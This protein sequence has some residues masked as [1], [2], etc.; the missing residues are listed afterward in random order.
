MSAR[1]APRARQIT[2]LEGL[3]ARGKRHALGQR[4]GC[5][6]TTLGL[7][8]GTLLLALGHYY[9]MAIVGAVAFVAYFAASALDPELADDRRVRVV[10]ALLDELPIDDAAPITLGL[11]LADCEIERP[12]DKTPIGAGK[13]RAKYEQR[14]LEL[15]FLAADGTRVTLEVEVHAT[16][17]HDGIA[18]A[19]RD[20]DEL[21]RLRFE[22]DG[23]EAPREVPEVRGWKREGDRF[24]IG[25]LASMEQLRDLVR[26]GLDEPAG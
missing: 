16:I 11:E 2:L 23:A 1:V 15:G 26:A 9:V 19:S 12:V 8:A 13:L 6:V 14:W 21:A 7:V 3:L 25:G 10:R 18:I 24:R 17:V 4:L 20:E 22:V 5:A